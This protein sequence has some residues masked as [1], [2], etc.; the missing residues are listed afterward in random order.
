MWRWTRWWSKASG[1]GRRDRGGQHRLEEDRADQD[2]NHAGDLG[3]HADNHSA[4]NDTGQ[5]HAYS[6]DSPALAEEKSAM[7]AKARSFIEKEVGAKALEELQIYAV[8]LRMQHEE[9]VQTRA[10]LEHARDEYRRLFHMTPVGNIVISKSG[11]ILRYNQTAA[12]KFGLSEHAAPDFYN[13]IYPRPC[14]RRLR[15]FFPNAVAANNRYT[16]GFK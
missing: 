7:A 5:P 11:Q 14:G 15:P 13:G 9:L 1:I 2:M 6:E 3:G 16:I 12:L 10:H 8:E 4:I